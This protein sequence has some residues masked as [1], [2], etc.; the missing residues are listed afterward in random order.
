MAGGSFNGGGRFWSEADFGETGIDS[1][2][3]W[4]SKYQREFSES[5]F[6]KNLS[7]IL[8]ARRIE[9]QALTEKDASHGAELKL[10]ELFLSDP[11]AHFADAK[12]YVL[13]PHKTAD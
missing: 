6:A 12:A 11:V 8:S 10:V 3:G 4:R 13:G 2:P 5:K 1:P 9:L 7:P